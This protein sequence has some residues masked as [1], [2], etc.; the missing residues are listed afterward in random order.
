MGKKVRLR[1]DE[2]GYAFALVLVLLILIG[3]IIGPLLLFMTTSL[4]SSYRHQGWMLEYYAA[5]AG[6]EDA[7]YKIQHEDS[8]LPPTAED[9]P[10]VY[11]IDGVN[12]NLVAVS[13]DRIEDPSDEVYKITSTA[14]NGGGSTTVESYIKADRV[15]LSGFGDNAITT[16][17]TVTIQPG[18]EIIPEGSIYYNPDYWPTATQLATYFWEDVKDETPFG[19]TIDVDATPI[20]GPLYRDGNLEIYNGGTAGATATLNGTVYVAGATSQLTIGQTNQDFTLDLNGQSIFV[21]G[22]IDIGGKCTITGS[23]SII[24]VG[25]IDFSPHVS[26]EEGDFVFLMSVDGTVMFWPQ[27]D[28]YGS[29][30]G[31]LEVQLQ[32]GT[33]LTWVDPAGAGFEFPSG[34][35]AVLDIRTYTIQ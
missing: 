29:V 13:I 9:A 14:T 26:S 1:K 30:A 28:F 35:E 25:D 10:L 24:A 7:A 8:N 15:D 32:P 2:G 11:E 12:G 4:M 31:N 33:T 19:G 17:G 20:I 5:D 27:D 6:I 21:E 3:L 23:G 16:N 22:E 18:S 34:G